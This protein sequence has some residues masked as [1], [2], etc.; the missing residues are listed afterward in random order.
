MTDQDRLGAAYH[1]AGHAIVAS[2]LG[3]TIE[4]MEIGINGDDAKGATDIRD[5]AGLPLA[6]QLAICA[7]GIEAQKIF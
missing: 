7:A 3:L 6:D 5:V 4:R 2:A 1:E